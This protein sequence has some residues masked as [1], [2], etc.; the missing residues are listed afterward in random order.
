MTLCPAPIT[1][2]PAPITSHPAPIITSFPPPSRRIPPPSS[3]HSRV[4]GN[5]PSCV[6]RCIHGNTCGDDKSN[7]TH[8]IPPLTHGREEVY[9]NSKTGY[10][11]GGVSC[12]R[13]I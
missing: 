11:L 6:R 10:G 4:G 2:Y 9:N 12:W 5:L 1:L 13:W 3:R 8:S 7:G